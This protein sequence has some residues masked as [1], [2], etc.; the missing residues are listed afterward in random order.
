MLYI[1]RSRHPDCLRNADNL[2][3]SA[4]RYL[5][6][7][8]E[9]TV[10]SPD[11][12]DIDALRWLLQK[13]PE[14]EGLVALIHLCYAIQVKVPHQL[15]ATTA[16]LARS[17][18]FSPLGL[19]EHS[20]ARYSRW[21]SL[22]RLTEKWFGQGLTIPQSLVCSPERDSWCSVAT[23]VEILTWHLHPQA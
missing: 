18:D 13:V 20:H 9:C 22:C 4:M 10:F 12:G 19:A 17:H 14:R 16:C 6:C 1:F 8:A 5:A 21:R 15:P 7:P 11:K 3:A 2:P 23:L